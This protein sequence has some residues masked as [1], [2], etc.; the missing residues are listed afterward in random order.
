MRGSD[1]V[2][3]SHRLYG[4]G[5]RQRGDAG[6]LAEIEEAQLALTRATSPAVREYAQRMITEH[7]AAMQREQQVMTGSGVHAGMHAGTGGATATGAGAAGAGIVVAGGGLQ[8]KVTT[9][10]AAR[11]TWPDRL[12]W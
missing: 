4:D 11:G 12:Y 1:A 8:K 10:R 2:R 9:T 7:G 5:P 6:G 3:G